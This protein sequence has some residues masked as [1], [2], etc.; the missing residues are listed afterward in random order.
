[1]QVVTTHRNTDFD[2]LASVIAVTI[3]YPETIPVLPKAVNPNVKALLSIHKDLFNLRTAREIDLNRIQRLIVVDVNQWNRLDGWLAS[4]NKRTDLDIV[5]WDHHTVSGDI[6][7]T[8][9]CCEN[10]GATVTLLI[11]KIREKK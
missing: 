2:G 3:L 4:L 6:S 7:A 5:L 9:A 11:R 8:T 10:V 1:M